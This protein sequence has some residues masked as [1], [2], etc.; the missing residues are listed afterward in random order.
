MTDLLIAI[1]SSGQPYIRANDAWSNI[2]SENLKYVTT[3]DSGT[4]G[5]DSRNHVRYRSSSDRRRWDYTGSEVFRNID[6]GPKGFLLGVRSNGV[7][8]YRDGMSTAVP[9]GLQWV[10]LGGTFKSVSVGSYGIWG[11]DNLGDVHFARRPSDLKVFPLSWRLINGPYLTKIDAGFG[12]N[13]WGVGSSGQVL[14]RDG[15]SH[16]TPFGTKWISFNDVNVNDITVGFNGIF[17]LHDGKIIK[18]DNGIFY[19]NF[20]FYFVYKKT[21]FSSEPQ[22]FLTFGEILVEIFLTFIGVNW[23]K[24]VTIIQDYQRKL[25]IFVKELTKNDLSCIFVLICQS[26]F[27]IY[28]F[29]DLPFVLF[30]L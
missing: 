27:I 26:I 13:V 28:L 4:W 29:I 30:R 9:Y 7:L 14:K 5:I 8:A 21:T 16:D 17:G 11:V 1:D 18:K 3:G 19:S 24:E 15:V 2:L 6:S 25:S 20:V 12:N 10:N 23:L 22:F